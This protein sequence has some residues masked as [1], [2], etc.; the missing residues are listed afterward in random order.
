[1]VCTACIDAWEPAAGANGWNVVGEATR[2]PGGRFHS[3]RH[4]T[5]KTRV[6]AAPVAAAVAVRIAALSGLVNLGNSCYLNSI[7]QQLL[8]DPRVLRELE[9]MYAG[10]RKP[11]S[12]FGMR[13][14]NAC[15][16][17][18]HGT[19]L[20]VH[21][22][23]QTVQAL[24][25]DEVFQRGSR[26]FGSVRRALRLECESRR[27]QAGACSACC[28]AV[29]LVVC[30]LNERMRNFSFTQHNATVFTKL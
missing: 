16:H 23:V 11:C 24:S 4:Q 14:A 2:G 22:S 8:R 9:A 21:A 7:L 20:R 13:C 3:S 25:E 10:H 26:P 12:C 30:A 17:A 18:W 1:V 19:P 15:A 29:Y 28:L 6:G 27:V 5:K